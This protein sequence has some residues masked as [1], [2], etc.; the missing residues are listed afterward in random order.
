M[1][2]TYKAESQVLKLFPNMLKEP[3]M[4]IEE[5]EK[6]LKLIHETGKPCEELTLFNNI[7]DKDEYIK[8]RDAAT[9]NVTSEHAYEVKSREA[10]N[11][12]AV[13]SKQHILDVYFKGNATT[14]KAADYQHDTLGLIGEKFGANAYEEA[15]EG[16][17]YF[18]I[19][20]I[21]V[22]NRSKFAEFTAAFTVRPDTKIH[23][24]LMLSYLVYEAWAH[25]KDHA[26]KEQPFSLDI[27]SA[28]IGY[29]WLDM[30]Q[31]PT[32]PTQLSYDTIEAYPRELATTRAVELFEWYSENVLKKQAPHI[33]QKF[34]KSFGSLDY[35]FDLNV[36][37]PDEEKEK[38]V[39]HIIDV[40]NQRAVFIADPV[41]F[42][43]IYL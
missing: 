43:K 16:S 34:E 22:K 24:Q 39:A 35:H 31:I 38:E 1:S 27:E 5:K 10:I 9:K 28:F 40:L 12:L 19:R 20:F 7:V 37:D 30:V 15:R 4:V 17:L 6:M 29:D 13:E 21:T 23:L 3:I 8:R 25:L 41:G 11:A 18:F 33:L 32:E 26:T 2:T 36:D 42:P 14:Y